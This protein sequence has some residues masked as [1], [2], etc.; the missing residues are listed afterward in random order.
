MLEQ[1][2]REAQLFFDFLCSLLRS[3]R[4]LKGK[5]KGFWFYQTKDGT[6]F[7]LRHHVWD[8]AVIIETWWL[9]EYLRNLGN[10]NE[11]VVVIDIGGHVGSFSIFMARKLSKAKIF[12]YEP[13]PGNFAL[14]KENI[15]LNHLE[16]RVF[17]F[18]LAIADKAGKKIRLGFHP[19]NLGMHSAV[20]LDQKPGQEKTSFEAKTTSLE[21]IFK[22][23]RIPQC[24]F[25]KMDCEGCEYPVLASAPRILLKK[26]S[27]LTLE[28]HPSGDI[29]AIKKHLEKA[30]FKTKF[31]RAVSN[32]LISWLVNVPLLNAWRGD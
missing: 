27:N 9:N 32:R 31:D 29:K 23:N 16:D 10:L 17:A 3:W 4:I 2:K 7:K 24:D 20:M 26:I 28:Y 25:L 5:K 19:Y 21:E 15:K 8:S 30:G 6:K 14:L 1:L 18:K 13:E 11:K 22:K 12:A